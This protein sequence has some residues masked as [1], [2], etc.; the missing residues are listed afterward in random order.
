MNVYN[1]S[2]GL[3]MC[4][5]L[6]HN[7]HLGNKKALFYNLR[8]YCEKN[9]EDIFDIVPLTFH[10]ENGKKDDQYLRFIDYFLKNKTK[11]AEEEKV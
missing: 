1:D 7:Y 10:I 3:K 2:S 4:N 8:E 5:H 11:I 9:K 6:D